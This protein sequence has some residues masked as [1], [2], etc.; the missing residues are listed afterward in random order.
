M[1]RFIDLKNVRFGRLIVLERTT[2]DRSKKA[3]WIC[4]CDC[5][6]ETIASRNDLRSGDKTSCGCFRKESLSKNIEGKVYGKLT[7]L[8]V[9]GKT[10]S[11][12]WMCKCECGNT[13][14]VTVNHLEMDQVKSCGCWFQKSEDQLLIEAKNRFF[15]NI[16]KN[17]CWNWVGK[18]IK[19]YGVIFYK[20]NMK[21]HRFSYLIHKG[22]LRS[23]MLICHHCDN[24]GCVNPDHLY[25]GTNQ[26]NFND[27]I[28]RGRFKPRGKSTPKLLKLR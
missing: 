25:Q 24:P 8:K 14:N 1:G 26:D 3:R 12:V 27:M 11:T 13:H 17:K 18:K 10:T 23:N 16:E 28:D 9:V 22:E 21:A 2:N 5:G 7:A 6:V 15:G 20:Q 19:G 4:H